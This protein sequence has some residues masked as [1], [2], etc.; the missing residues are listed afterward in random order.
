MTRTDHRTPHIVEGNNWK[1]AVIALFEPES[2]YRPWRHGFGKA[3][4][5]DPVAVV[6]YTDPASVLTRLRTSATTAI[7][8]VRSLNRHHRA[9]SSTWTR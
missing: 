4:A 7:S 1:D 9:A 2:P 3:H 6:V 5:G 8:A